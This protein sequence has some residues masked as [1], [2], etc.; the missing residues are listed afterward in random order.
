MPSWSLSDPSLSRSGWV[1]SRTAPSAGEGT[2]WPRLMARLTVALF[3]RYCGMATSAAIE[4]I[5]WWSRTRTI[6]AAAAAWPKRT[7]PWGYYGALFIISFLRRITGD[8]VS[9]WT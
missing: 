6:D 7:I 8:K 1:A 4:G 5:L 9:G 2:P 3:P